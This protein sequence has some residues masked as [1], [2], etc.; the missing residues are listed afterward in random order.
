MHHPQQ[1]DGGTAYPTAT[2]GFFKM[3]SVLCPS[4]CKALSSLKARTGT[5]TFKYL[6]EK[7]YYG[8]SVF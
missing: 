6:C 1:G 7:S 4:E 5:Y 8:V 2:P 3:C